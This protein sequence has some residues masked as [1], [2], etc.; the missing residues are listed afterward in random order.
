LPVTHSALLI[1]IFIFVAFCCAVQASVD[2][3]TSGR[4]LVL[5]VLLGLLVGAKMPDA[6]YWPALPVPPVGA[7]LF[8]VGA[9]AYLALCGVGVN[10]LGL[11]LRWPRRSGL[12]A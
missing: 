12:G 6:A 2:T 5:A 11:C 10:L 8:W 9:I 7:N 4:R 1:A 3:P